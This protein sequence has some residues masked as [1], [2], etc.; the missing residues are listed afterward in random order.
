MSE[1]RE[2]L[3]NSEFV[4][5]AY[6]EETSEKYSIIVSVVSDNTS[7]TLRSLL[8]N[9]NNKKPVKEEAKEYLRNL[10]NQ[11]NNKMYKV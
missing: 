5:L 7:Y 8:Y 6:I 10:A 4:S 3:I 1:N 11:I 2:H 9:E